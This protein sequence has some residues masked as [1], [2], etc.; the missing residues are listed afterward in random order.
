MQPSGNRKPD[1]SSADRRAAGLLLSRQRTG[2]RFRTLQ[3]QLRHCFSP[4]FLSGTGMAL[5][6]VCF[7]PLPSDHDEFSSARRRSFGPSKFVLLAMVLCGI[8]VGGVPLANSGIWAQLCCALRLQ[9][10]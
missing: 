3:P 1:V 5:I 6:A 10:W 2:I 4:L 9:A 8:A 7:P